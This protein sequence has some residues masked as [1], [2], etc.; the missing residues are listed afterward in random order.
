[1]D[2]DHGV[3]N[4]YSPM[5]LFRQYM[6]YRQPPNMPVRLQLDLLSGFQH[7]HFCSCVWLTH[8]SAILAY[9][10]MQAQKAWVEHVQNNRSV[11][12]VR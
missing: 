7:A 12:F 3:G 2:A 1:M 10:S 8:S 11:N 5:S 6:R 9:Q 4:P